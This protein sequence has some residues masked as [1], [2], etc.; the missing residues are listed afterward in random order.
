MIV[1]TSGHPDYRCLVKVTPYWYYMIL[2]SRII[3]TMIKYFCKG[4]TVERASRPA[5]AKTPFRFN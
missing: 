5:T 1:R 2:S 3:Y 4:S